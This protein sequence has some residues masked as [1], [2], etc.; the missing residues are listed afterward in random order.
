MSLHKM[1]MVII[2]PSKYNNFPKDMIESVHMNKVD[3][4]FAKSIRNPYK[5]K[6]PS[7]TSCVTTH[8]FVK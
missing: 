7:Y 1:Y 5:E 8:F 3:F 4:S 6:L 2:F